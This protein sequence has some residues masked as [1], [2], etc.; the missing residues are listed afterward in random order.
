MQD[1]DMTVPAWNDLL[2][3][4]AGAARRPPEADMSAVQ[5][6]YGPLVAREPFVMAQVGQSI[7]GRVSTLS[8]DARDI[9][10]PEGLRHL[11]RCRALMDAVIVGAGTVLA[12]NPLLTVREV[13]GPNP[14]RVVI[15]CR[16]S[17]EGNE[18]LFREGD[19]PVIVFT[20]AGRH[21]PLAGKA[22]VIQ[23]PE[24]PDGLEP[25]A[26]LEAL[27]ARG[28]KRVLVEGGARTIARFLSHRCL[29]RLHVAIAPVII[30]SGKPGLTLPP[31]GALSEALR[32]PV[33]P[34]RL[35]SDV[36]F[37]CDLGGSLKEN[38]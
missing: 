23:L 29:D 3:R 6:L 18:R 15:D 8:G 22:Q 7:D 5:R 28:L 34:Y 26:M 13:E 9:S 25:S 11:H 10:G 2:S 21:S 36:L 16:A 24:G 20:A 37:D 33:T 12:D 17:L 1:I 38:G 31:I 19:S 27:A 35:G 30:G 4:K 32:P 14:V